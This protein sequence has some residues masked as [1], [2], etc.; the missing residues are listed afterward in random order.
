MRQFDASDPKQLRTWLAEL[1]ARHPGV[2]EF[3]EAVTSVIGHLGRE[4]LKVAAAL[5]AKGRGQRGGGSEAF[6]AQQA[7][8]WAERAEERAT[9]GEESTEGSAAGAGSDGAA[10]EAAS[11]GDPEPNGD[12]PPPPNRGHR[13]PFPASWPRERVDLPVGAADR[14]CPTCGKDRICIGHDISEIL[15]IRPA[16]VY[17][18]Q[19]FR[20]KLACED[21][22]PG[23]ATAPPEPR[24]K[25][26][27][28][29]DLSISLDLLDRKLCQHLP[30]H[31]VVD[32][33]AR[34]GCAVAEKTLER[35]Y[36]D[37]LRALHVVACAIRAQA[38]AKARFMLNIDDTSIPI[39]AKDTPEGRLIGHVW[40]VVGDQRFVAATVS[41]DWKKEHAV[42]AL[43]DW[44]GYVQC[45][46][47]RGFDGVFRK[48]R[49]IEVGC[50]A[51]ARRYF[52]KAR[53]RGDKLAEEVLG[54]IG[55]LY[56]VEAEATRDELDPEGRLALRR[57][58]SRRTLELLWK[59]QQKVGAG[60]RPKS[61]LG[62]ALT[63]LTNQRQALERFLEDGRLPLDNTV[64]EREM[65][66]VALGRKNWLFAGSY[67][68]AERLA[69][70]LTVIAT[71]RMHGVD[72]VAYL[73]WLL[74]QLA[75]REWSIEAAG[76]QLLPANFQQALKQ[77]PADAVV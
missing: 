25:Q 24:L 54:L 36:H 12:D 60:T 29:C 51:H 13:Q 63:Y 65:R 7:I 19:V 62:K 48:G 15:A 66:P 73:A 41:K 31:R 18:K 59:W 52:V 22:H 38:R 9:E 5:K 69:D 77:K 57:E 58:R 39:L 14:S 37:S 1:H 71:A 20:E 27:S 23:V 3:D 6:T 40:M 32:L 45:D 17:I 34:R 56:A 42:A 47:Y 8:E 64:V 61:P 49:M 16:E 26:Q 44:Q 70:G 50:W 28:S 21:G 33:Y 43:G 30:I 46:A 74:P 75:R 67:E 76:A 55:R 68:A 10:T 35:W 53:D 2:D 72:P 11:T 4:Y